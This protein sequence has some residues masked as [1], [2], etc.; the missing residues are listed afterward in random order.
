MPVLRK[1]IYTSCPCCFTH[2]R[3]IFREKEEK[4]IKNEDAGASPFPKLPLAKTR[5]IVY[6]QI[7]N[8]QRIL[9]RP[10]IAPGN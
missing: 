5:W 6:N 1:C 10:M 2:L 9:A 3:D 7:R 4:Q 8:N